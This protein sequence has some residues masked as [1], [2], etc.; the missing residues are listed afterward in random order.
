MEARVARV[1]MLLLAAFALTNVFML[2]RRLVGIA[3]LWLQ[4]SANRRISIF[5]VA[6]LFDPCRSYGC[7]VHVMGNQALY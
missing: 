5:F 6:E 7:G 2:A 4:P 3:L 1:A